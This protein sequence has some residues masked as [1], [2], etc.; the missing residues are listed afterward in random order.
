MPGC[1]ARQLFALEQNDVAP[2]ELAQMVGNGAADDA[3]AHDDDPRTSGKIDGHQLTP[4]PQITRIVG[5]LRKHASMAAFALDEHVESAPGCCELR[6]DTGKHETLLDAMAIGAGCRDPDAAI[7]IE[8]GLATACIG[9]GG[10]DF[11]VD[12]FEW[13][14]RLDVYK[15]QLELYEPFA[16]SGLLLPQKCLASDESPRL[17]ELYREAETLSLIH[18]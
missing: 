14:R 12:D 17:V 1:A 13:A 6:L 3:P 5:G 16:Q 11:G 4:H 10:R 15:R 2:T 7:L 18:I 9:I 8:H